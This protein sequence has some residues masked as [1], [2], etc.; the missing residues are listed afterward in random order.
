VSDAGDR[1]RPDRAERRDKPG[2]PSG[3]NDVRIEGRRL[4]HAVRLLIGRLAS[5]GLP[6]GRLSDIAGQVESIVAALGPAPRRPSDVHA[7]S[8]PAA[9]ARAFVDWSP[10]AGAANPVA[11]PMAMESVDGRVVG[12]V[13][14]GAAYEGP[15]GSV[16]GGCIAG[17]FDEILGR[18]G[19]EAG[20]PAVTG[21][22]KV[23]YRHPTPLETDL[24][25]VGI[26]V[27]VSGRRV[28]TRGELW[29]GDVMTAEAEGLF[30]R[31]VGRR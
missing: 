20:A 3:P 10:L 11:P 26:L 23:R 27:T 14:F 4:G 12:H 6:A 8:T 9:G 28:R 31:A 25:Y 19:A 15:P 5:G 24:T 1:P 2:E 13:R 29:A 18:A 21:T 30:V 7:G 22:L 17:G 16:H